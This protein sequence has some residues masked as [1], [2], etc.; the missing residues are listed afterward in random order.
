VQR[1][2]SELR[3]AV[4]DQLGLCEAL[5]WQ[6]RELGKRS[7]LVCHLD[8]PDSN[9]VLP[10]EAATAV[11]RILLE[12]ISNILRHAEARQAWVRLSTERHGIGTELRLEIRDDGKGITA[13]QIGHPLSFGLAGMRERLRA[14][15]G[16]LQVF[17]GE[18]CGTVVAATIP[19]EREW[20]DD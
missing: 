15:N 7:G 18:G 10:E 4:L 8:L 3:P 12:G 2:I 11:F 17:G 13:A 16:T 9:P 14:W 20:R 1:I 6:V 19:L 5:E